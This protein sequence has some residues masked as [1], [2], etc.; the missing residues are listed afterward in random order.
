MA[1]WRGTWDSGTAYVFDDSVAYG[2]SLWYCAA[3]SST[4][5]APGSGADWAA[6]ETYIGTAAGSTVSEGFGHAFAPTQI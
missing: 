1:N 4:G 3:S 5:Q 2:A 6:M